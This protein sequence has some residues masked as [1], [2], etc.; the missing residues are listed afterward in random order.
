M[1][2]NERRT[3]GSTV[4]CLLEPNAVADTAGTTF[5]RL[6]LLQRARGRLDVP[7]VASGGIVDGCGMAA[8]FALGAEGVWMGTRFI[9]ST[10]CPCHGVCRSDVSGYGVWPRTQALR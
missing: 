7:V 8:A 5:T 6:P 2:R 4:W 9:S 3:P 10:E 1:R